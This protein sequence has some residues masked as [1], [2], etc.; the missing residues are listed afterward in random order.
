[1]IKRIFDFRGAPFLAIVFIVLIV[2]EGKRQL[3]KRHQP[4]FKRA[5]INSLVSIPSFT[6]L[7][8]LL[9]PVTG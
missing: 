6:L 7:R 2:A 5:V 9:I 1:M 8:F 3:R 4:R